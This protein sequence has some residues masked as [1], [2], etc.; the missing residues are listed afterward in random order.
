M[1]KGRLF[2][3]SGPSGAGKG[4][5]CR[6]LLKQ[7]DAVLSISMTTREPRTGEVNGESYHFISVGEFTQIIEAGG[8]LEYAE[9]YGNYYGTPKKE[10]LE[11]L[12]QGVDVILEIDVQGALLIKERFPE[13][14]LLFLLPPTMSEL[15]GRIK[16]RGTEA[17]DEIKLR[18]SGTINEISHMDQYDYYVV[19]N[20]LKATVADVKT[21]ISAQRFKVTGAVSEVIEKYK[22][23]INALSINK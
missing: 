3:V 15:T 10:V 12:R 21:I 11:K 9:V 2:V 17:D 13:A 22:E 19:N 20:N 16:K 23:E 18:M 1:G 4:T 5:V 14:I 7:I 8:F 6:M